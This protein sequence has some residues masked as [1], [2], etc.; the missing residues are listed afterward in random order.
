MRGAMQCFWY[1]WSSEAGP[2]RDADL[3]RLWRCLAESGSK[4]RA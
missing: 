4:Q 3:C 2:A 1:D